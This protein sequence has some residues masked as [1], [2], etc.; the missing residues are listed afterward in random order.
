MRLSFCIL[1]DFEI[2]KKLFL[3]LLLLIMKVMSNQQRSEKLD[4]FEF[5]CLSDKILIIMP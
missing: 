3:L 4:A 5:S 2:C 1:P